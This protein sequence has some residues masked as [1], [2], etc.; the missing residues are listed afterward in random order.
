MGLLQHNGIKQY[1]VSR[2]QPCPICQKTHGC[3]LFESH[4]VCL[5]VGSDQPAQGGLGG[6]RHSLQEPELYRAALSTFSQPSSERLAPAATLDKVYRVLHSNLTLSAHHKKH[7]TQERQ[8]SAESIQ[9]RGYQSWGQGDRLLRSRL[10][11]VLY[12]LFGG[13][14]LDVP[15]FLL[16][17]QSRTYLTLGGPAGILIPIRNADGQI[18]AHQIRTDRPGDS[19]KY[20]WLSSTSRGGPGPGSPVHVS[21]PLQKTTSG[22]VWLT[23]G[24]LK[25]DIA[26]ERLGEVVLALPGVQADRHFLPTLQRLQERGEISELVIALDSDW[27]EKSAVAGARLKLA[28]A[29]ARQ[30]IPVWLADWTSEL[31]GLDDLLVA[32]GQPKLVAYQV[33]GNGKRP[34]DESSAPATPAQPSMSLEDARAYMETI[35]LQALEGELGNP[36]ELGILLSPL[37]GTGKSTVLSQVLNRYHRNRS[38]RRYSAYF[39]PRHD[40][41]ENSDRHSWALLSGRTHADPETGQTPCAYPERQKEIARLRIPG[42]VGCEHCPLQAACKEAQQPNDLGLPYYWGQ[43]Q[44]PGKVRVYPAQHFLTPSLWGS[45]AAVVLDD[46]DSKSLM[47]ET[48]TLSQSYLGFA[49]HWAEQHLSHLYTK[50]QPLLYLFYEV[51][52]TAPAGQVFNWDGSSL[53]SLLEE[54]AKEHSLS[55]EQVLSDASQAKEPDPFEENNLLDGPK[56]VPVR[57]LEPLLEI[58][59]H[60]WKEFKQEN[61]YNRRLRLERSAPGQEAG[62]RL[63]LRRELPSAALA[64][65]LLI[66]SDA[67]LT[68]EEARR[69]YPE[70]RWIEVKP[71]LRM[72]A[73]AQIIQFTD[74]NYGKI[75]LATPKERFK[76]LQRIGELV[77]QHPGQRI[78][79]I[80]HQSFTSAVRLHFP[81]IQVGHYYGQR[82]SNEFADC[83]VLICFGTPNPNPQELERQA[84]ALYWDQVVINPQTLLEPRVFEQSGGQVLQ[85]RVRAYRDPRLHEMHR[86]KRE[87]ELLQA[88]FRARPLSLD[89]QYRKNQQ[90]D[91][92][93]QDEE[94]RKKPRQAVVV[95]VFSSLPLPGLTVQARSL[96]QPVLSPD[97]HSNVIQLEEAAQR[98]WREKQRLTDARILEASQVQRASLRH[99]KRSRP[100]YKVEAA[101]PPSHGPPEAEFREVSPELVANLF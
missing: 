26:S 69:L 47:L 83:D 84:E 16:R 5:R 75:H 22:R 100:T 58:L 37:P 60:E 92:D 50:A 70:R 80:S 29:A 72:P 91:L 28:E 86:A 77:A 24:P 55:F 64:Q 17:E 95:Y 98:I 8:L 74:Y 79:L 35:L 51:L 43:F 90:L 66:L 10:A 41:A 63:T 40:L 61:P 32:G 18:V 87:E 15:G 93:F 13:V 85:T 12:D 1:R 34:F 82:G 7:L 52:R 71:N 99:W 38:P 96:A 44:Q 9:A 89:P 49:L 68:L 20:V 88:I 101:A 54:K 62:F 4:V 31:K 21:R 30:G 59:Q 65:S 11:E 27:H 67:S 78:G 81:H 36:K 19:G 45:P 48:F 57:F 94:S 56:A 25:A 14:V 42:Q 76:A 2:Q 33:S 53:M 46:C 6:W 23:E 39:V 73:A 3:L 97:N